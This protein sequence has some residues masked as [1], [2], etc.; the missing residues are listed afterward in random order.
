MHSP[1]LR[2]TDFELIVDG[3][4]QSHADYFRGFLRTGRLGLIA[5]NG[6]DGA[7]VVNLLMAHVTAFYDD[8]R[9]ESD[10]FFAYPDFFAFQH[11]LPVADYGM[12][13]IWPTHK[14]VH[15]APDPLEVLQ[16]VTDRGVNVLLV[17]DGTHR[18]HAFNDIALASARRNIDQ[19]YAYAFEGH[20]KNADIAIRC[21]REP[22]AQWVASMFDTCKEGEQIDRRCRDW[23][24]RCQGD[25]LE[26][27]YRRLSLEEALGRL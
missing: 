6:P 23:L 14:C 5:P 26:Q 27:T 22:F 9:A 10:A 19:C 3:R 2:G 25:T 15:V 4:S 7:G 21:S 17:P 8:Y 13:D 12:L 11:R 16:A 1:T 18:D 20:V 24:D